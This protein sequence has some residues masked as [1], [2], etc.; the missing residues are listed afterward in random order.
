VDFGI[1]NIA[2]SNLYCI[3]TCFLRQKVCVIHAKNGAAWYDKLV[4]DPI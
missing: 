3:A 4:V 2:F 1:N